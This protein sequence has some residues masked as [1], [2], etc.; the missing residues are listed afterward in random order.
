[1]Y[2]SLSLKVFPFPCYLMNA[3]RRLASPLCMVGFY[4]INLWCLPTQAEII[5]IQAWVQSRGVSCKDVQT[6]PMEAHLG[7]TLFTK[8]LQS[9]PRARI[10][11]QLKRVAVQSSQCRSPYK[12][13][14]RYHVL[15]MP[16]CLFLRLN[17]G[18]FVYAQKTSLC[19]CMIFKCS[20]VDA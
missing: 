17:L 15:V 10:Y 8:V 18:C 3:C 1:M 19:T 4:H 5:V 11:R 16:L 13:N 9:C 6:G 2:R 7:F 20:K 12:A 14:T